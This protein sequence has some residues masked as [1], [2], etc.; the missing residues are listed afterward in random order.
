M[1]RNP[2]RTIPILLLFTAVA[3]ISV[4][5]AMPQSASGGNGS[6]SSDTGTVNSRGPQA[7][8]TNSTATSR[9]TAGASNFGSAGMNSSGGTGGSSARTWNAGVGSFGSTVQP[10]GIWRTTA[11]PSV[12]S[13]AIVGRARRPSILMDTRKSATG[14]S[15]S[16]RAPN[17]LG[18]G[19]PTQSTASLG[20]RVRSTASALPMAPRNTFGRQTSP[21]TSNPSRH[22]GSAKAKRTHR[23]GH[24]WK[25]PA[26]DENVR[27]IFSGRTGRDG[28]ES[29][30]SGGGLD[31]G[32][33]RLGR[34]GIS[35]QGKPGAS[36]GS[37]NRRTGP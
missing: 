8:T 24:P 36:R 15:S 21:S 31:D 14:L 12:V 23:S 2:S 29:A 20:S 1:T 33:N 25:G 35:K 5:V 37:D 11:A 18:L 6:R 9:W 34:S 32:I 19:R 17:Q 30:P 7:L 13:P 16:T 3:V 10:G 28:S 27:D 22:A 4:R 26:P